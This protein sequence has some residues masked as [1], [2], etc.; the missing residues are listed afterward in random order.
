[1]KTKLFIFIGFI[2]AAIGTSLTFNAAPVHAAGETYKWVN[3]NTIEGSGGAYED[4]Y[5]DGKVSFSRGDDFSVSIIAVCAEPLTISIVPSQSNRNGSLISSG[6]EGGFIVDNPDFDTE[7]S[8]GDTQN[9]PA[10][11]GSDIDFENLDCASFVNNPDLG[12]NRDQERWRCEAI[13]GCMASGASQADCFDAWITCVD[14]TNNSF[15]CRNDLVSGL[16]T[17]EDETTTATT[18]DIDGLGWIVCPIVTFL[19]KLADGSYSTIAGF[20]EVQ[21]LLTTGTSEPIYQAWSIMR[22]FANVAF[23]IA[24]L[25][26]IFSQITS[27]GISNYGIKKMLPRLI[28]AAIL[29][30][31]SYWVCAILID[32]TNI[33]GYSI[34]EVFD[35]VGASFQ[36]PEFDDFAGTGG[37]GAWANAVMPLIAGAVLVGTL[38]YVGLSAALPILIT[39]LFALLS[40]FVVLAIRQ[41]LIILLVVV[42]PLAFVAFL[43]PNTQNLFSKWRGLFQNLLLIFPIVSF[44]FGASALASQVVTAS[45]ANIEDPTQKFV[46][47]FLGAGIAVIPLGITIFITQLTKRISSFVGDRFGGTADRARKGA[48]GVRERQQQ[49][50]NIRALG[51]GRVFGGAGIRRRARRDAIR[52]GLESEAKRAQSGYV[53]EQAREDATFR[54]R[55]GGGLATGPNASP[56]ALSRAMAGA[57]NVEA[58]LSADEIKAEHAIIKDANLDS[59]IGALQKLAT[60]G[61]AVYKDRNGVQREMTAAPG[62]ALQTASIQRQMEIGDIG[63][64]D[65]LVSSSGSM[66]VQ[67]RQAI[68]EGMSRLSG[69]ARYYGGDASARVA[70][71]NIKGESDLDELVSESIKAGK[72]SAQI[73]ADSDKEALT[74]ISKVASTDQSIGD[75]PKMNLMLAANKVRTDPMIKHPDDRSMERINSIEEGE[76]FTSP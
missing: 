60:G 69:K 65:K 40:A 66:G 12:E 32:I 48:E 34:K 25:I 19:A 4:L 47:Q 15:S 68:A 76:N 55:L 44:I 27:V 3:V 45:A 13:Q 24:F 35:G 71:G 7:F 67:Q 5:S 23:V 50:R 6:C 75:D 57:I 54:N 17:E 18:C 53:A 43:L 1:M 29:V 42:S 37:D 14:E 8:I 9:G 20:L 64:T 38:L 62:S 39:A 30:N 31:V 10:T 49:R 2:A 51:S 61:T 36:T 63:M 72:Y 11:P 21:P 56:E 46:T 33:L 41:A 28:I 73:L 22:N 26:I 59:D 16:P 58:S 74:R 52:G 70:A